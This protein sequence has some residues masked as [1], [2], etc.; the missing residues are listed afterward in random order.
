M[1]KFT[2]ILAAATFVVALSSCGS[3]PAETTEATA[4][5]TAMAAPAVDSAAMAAPAADS[6]AMAAPAD[7]TKK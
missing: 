2:T 7:T 3:K 6:A 4:D 5:S 1:K